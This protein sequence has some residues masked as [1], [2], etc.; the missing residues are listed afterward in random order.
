MSECVPSLIN[1][2]MLAWARDE[3]GMTL[4]MSAERSGFPEHKLEAWESSKLVPTLTEA[5][6]LAVVY[7]RPYLLLCMD[8]PP[9]STVLAKEYR[10]LPGVTPE[11]VP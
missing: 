4:A 10:R 7:Q 9:V 2:A 1:P 11:R 5:T 6:K 8:Q 3:A